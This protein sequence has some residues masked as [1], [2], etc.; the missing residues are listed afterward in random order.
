MVNDVLLVGQLTGAVDMT[1]SSTGHSV[2]RCWLRV[3]EPQ[4]G[5]D[6]WYTTNVPLVGFGQ[7]ADTLSA[8]GTGDVLL[9]RGR[10]RYTP[11]DD[12][13]YVAPYSVEVFAG[14]EGCD[15]GGN[16]ADW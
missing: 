4:F 6:R 15:S 16:G 13:L 12:G 5:G 2:A 8:Y 14:P 9:V 10:L 11:T 7:I 1:R 3:S